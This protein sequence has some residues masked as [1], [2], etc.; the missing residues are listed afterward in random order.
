M[1]DDYGQTWKDIS[2]NIPASPVNVIKEDPKNENLLYLGTDNGAYVS[3]DMGTSWEVFSEGLPNVAVHD[4]VVQP[5][6]NDLLLGTH[7]RS[8]YK[9]N[10]DALQQ[11]NSDLKSKPITIFEVSPVRHSSRWGS[12]WSPWSEAYAPNKTIQFYSSTSG[13]KTMTVLSENGAVLNS[14]QLKADKGFNY[15]DYDL[16]LSE[17]G[18]KALEKENKELKI[19]KSGNG[20]YY[21]PK[22]VYT[23]EIDDAKSTLEVK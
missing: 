1:S 7:G 10:I 15:V 18:K 14:I 22:G 16:T 13:E 23:I 3:F 21:L 12:A 20:K 17:K 5:E 2:G 19:G 4:M 6:A 11:M 9:A 8:I